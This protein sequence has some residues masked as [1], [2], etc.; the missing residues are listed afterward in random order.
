MA[1][2]CALAILVF[3]LKGITS[4]YLYAQSGLTRTIVGYWFH[5]LFVGLLSIIVLGLAC[6]CCLGAVRLPLMMRSGDRGVPTDLGSR[7]GRLLTW[8]TLGRRVVGVLVTGFI[9]MPQIG[10]RGAFAVLGFLLAGAVLIFALVNRRLL[11]GGLATV[12]TISLLCASFSGGEDW[13]A[14]LSGGIFRLDDM[15]FSAPVSPLQTF[16]DYRSKAVKLL[17][18]R[19]AADATVSVERVPMADGSVDICL[20]INGKVDA[21][22]T[23]D[24]PTQLMLAH[25]PLM[26]RPGS[27][28]VFCFGMGSGITAGTVLDYPVTNLTIAENC[29]PVLQAA[30]LFA[31]WNHGVYT[32]DRTHIYHDDARTVLKLSPHQYDAIIAEPSNPWMAGV[33]S[34]FSREFYQL[35][36]SRLKPGGL[37]TQWFHIYEMD[38]RTLYLVLRTFASVFPKMEIWDLGDNDII[39]LGSQQAWETGPDIYRKVFALSQPRAD[40]ATIGLMEPETVPARQFA[41]QQTA[42]AIPGPGSIHTD[43]HP[44]LDY[45][46][47][48][49][50][51]LFRTRG[52]INDFFN[53]DE[54]TWQMEIA[55]RWKDEDLSHLNFTDLDPDISP[56]FRLR[57]C[58]ITTISR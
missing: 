32:N 16:F 54:R 4:I 55:P 36:A 27:K 28:D 14:I 40:L 38:D 31:Q 26:V 10:L 37:M 22:A 53:Y 51:Y 9:L 15:D 46:A 45:E 42:F 48:K 17:F 11:I 18:Y 1:P 57:R 58:R 5:Q 34:V 2:A 47:P 44:I 20:R 21:S 39:L 25:L 6:S 50:F 52:G 23:G 35:A 13:R 29:E 7:V 12:A 24:R 8:N 43:D 49:A 33:A 19:D 56:R 41:S 3:D 30:R